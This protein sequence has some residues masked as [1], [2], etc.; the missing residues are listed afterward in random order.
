MA[1]ADRPEAPRPQA[2]RAPGGGRIEPAADLSAE[3]LAK[4]EAAGY[5]RLRAAIFRR[6]VRAG[7]LARGLGARARW[8]CRAAAAIYAAWLAALAVAAIV[9]RMS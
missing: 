5:A 4:A 8:A 6:P 1:G 9:H 7:V 3:A 2:W